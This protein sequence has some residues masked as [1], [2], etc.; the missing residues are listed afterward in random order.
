[1]KNIRVKI[2]KT[3][4]LPA[5]AAWC[6]ESLKADDGTILLDVEACLGE[7][8]DDDG[9]TVPMNRARVMVG[10]LMHEFGHALEEAL[11]L[12]YDEDFVEDVTSK[13]FK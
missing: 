3:D 7:L 4:G 13:Y 8:V 10:T 9:K 12:K 2:V 11:G 6:D 5:F 1:M